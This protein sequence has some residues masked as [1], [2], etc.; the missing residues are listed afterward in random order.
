MKTF[1]IFL[2]NTDDES[3]SVL[4][5]RSK[6]LLEFKK[7]L[8]GFHVDGFVVVGWREHVFGYKRSA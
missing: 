1:L 5:F 8:K 2:E 3:Q 6:T 4:G 7:F